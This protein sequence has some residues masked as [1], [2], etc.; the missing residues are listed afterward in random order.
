MKQNIT[1]AVEKSILRQ[2][3]ELAVQRGASVSGLLAAELQRLVD[4]G[5][6]WE[7]AKGRALTRL[8]APF[9]LGGKKRAR[10]E[11]LHDRSNLR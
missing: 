4:T 5:A 3:R 1:L 10:R 6:A 9:H 11:D 2:A 8:Q 7:Q